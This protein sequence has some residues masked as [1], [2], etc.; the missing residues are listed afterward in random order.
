MFNKKG[1][2]NLNDIDLNNFNYPELEI[3]ISNSKNDTAI[4]NDMMELEQKFINI[5]K[6]RINGLEKILESYKKGN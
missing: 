2:Y 3:E 1:N 5:M 6:K 4:I